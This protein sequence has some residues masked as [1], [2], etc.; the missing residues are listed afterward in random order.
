[1]K[2]TPFQFRLVRY[3]V[4]SL[5][6]TQILWRQKLMLCNNKLVGP[7][8]DHGIDVLTNFFN[9]CKFIEEI[10]IVERER[11]KKLCTSL[12]PSV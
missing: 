5:D 3:V 9:R 11:K 1:M 6:F 10:N 4:K 12:E 7:N 2:L 8:H